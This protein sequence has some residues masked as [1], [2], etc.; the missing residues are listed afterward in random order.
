MF[1]TFYSSL[2]SESV[3]LLR[4][5]V[6]ASNR[7]RV[8]WAR[9]VNQLSLLAELQAGPE[10][11]RAEFNGGKTEH[12]IPR[13]EYYTKLQHQVKALLERGLSS[14]VQAKTHYQVHYCHR[15]FK[16]Q[17]VSTLGAFPV[18]AFPPSISLKAKDWK[19]AWS[20]SLMTKEWLKPFLTLD[21][22]MGQLY[23]CCHYGSR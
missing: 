19:R 20:S 6:P 8:K 2:I 17:Y 22:K 5:G 15:Y 14:S 12:K 18:F 9:G 13:W 21:Q 11:L 16:Q 1:Y 7:A 4:A 23:W 3:C 10:H